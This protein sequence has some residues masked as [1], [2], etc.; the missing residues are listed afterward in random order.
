MKASFTLLTQL[1]Q[2]AQTESGIK[3]SKHTLYDFHTTVTS[4]PAVL[5][6]RTI[7]RIFSP[8]ERVIPAQEWKNYHIVPFT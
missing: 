7:K 6:W 4:A 5:P 1:D 8:G 2:Q 3:T